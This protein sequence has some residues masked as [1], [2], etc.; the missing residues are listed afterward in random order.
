MKL[1]K[2]K[3]LTPKERFLYWIMER[4]AI[5]KKRERGLLRPWTD[6]EVLQTVWF[7]NPYREE[8]KTTV[9]F[10]NYVRKPLKDADSVLMA[11]VIFRWFNRIPTGIALWNHDL[12][13]RWD[14][15]KA[16]ETLERMPPPIFTGAYMIKAG[17]G[18]PGCKIGNVCRSITP[19]WNDRAMLVQT[20]KD[21]NSLKA[22][23][24]KL[25]F[26]KHL[27]GFMAYEIVCDLRY[28][29]LL[30]DATDV[31]TWANMGPGARRG[32]NRLLG[33]D[34]E[35]PLSQREWLVE[36][37]RLLVDVRKL[38]LKPKMELREVEHANCE[39]DKY[40]RALWKQGK[41]KRKYNGV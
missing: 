4:R 19:L 23:W 41:L 29:H 6:D 18:P 11:T 31:N 8:D 30:C 40:E 2:V 34:V 3:K 15:R 38:R 17:N 37:I 26:Y 27:G 9:W 24:D 39:W 10:R 7:T 20:C 22:I 36:A 12:L 28:T 5:H 1:S 16:I 13:T 33:R 14:E 21:T 35:A 25:R 32:M